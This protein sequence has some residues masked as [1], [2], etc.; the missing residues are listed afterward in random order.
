MFGKLFKPRS[1]YV[2]DYKPRYYNERKERLQNLEQKYSNE[3]SSNEEMNTLRLTKNN[4]RNDWV[5]NKRS[6]TDRSTNLRLA[7]II[8]ILVGIAAYIF[9]LHSFF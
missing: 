6:A 5:K 8:V 4:L 3:N 2:F 1:H 9:D 7:L